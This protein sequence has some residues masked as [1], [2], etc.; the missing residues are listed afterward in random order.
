MFIVDFLRKIGDRLSNPERD[1]AEVYLHSGSRSQAA[2]ML[3]L[4]AHHRHDE[5]LQRHGASVDHLR[6]NI[7]NRQIPRL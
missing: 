2:F 6:R 5:E 1:A 7:S 4:R 3:A